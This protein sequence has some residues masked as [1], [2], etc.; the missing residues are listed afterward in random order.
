MVTAQWTQGGI[1]I[2]TKQCTTVGSVVKWYKQYLTNSAKSNLCT[3]AKLP[4]FNGR[5]VTF[6]CDVC[7]LFVQ[8]G[9]ISAPKS[10]TFCDDFSCVK[11]CWDQ[12]CDNHGKISDRDDF[13][14]GNC[15]LD[16]STF[17]TFDVELSATDGQLQSGSNSEAT[18]QTDF[19]S[20]ESLPLKSKAII[21]LISAML[22][23]CL[24]LGA[25]LGHLT[26]NSFS[27][28]ALVE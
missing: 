11:F 15:L 7:D 2:N 28:K 21:F 3:I 13:P 4:D 9:V 24:Y 26:S 12:D 17:S 18:D 19:Y 1:P 25:H 22:R 16:Q 6:I 8:W 10:V 20:Q 23:N 14:L 5:I 27:S